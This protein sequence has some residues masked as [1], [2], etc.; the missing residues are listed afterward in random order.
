MK[1]FFRSLLLILAL[2]GLLMFLS[3]CG[4]GTLKSIG[5]SMSGVPKE[6]GTH[7][8]VGYGW[9][10]WGEGVTSSGGF[11]P[12]LFSGGVNMVFS[13]GCRMKHVDPFITQM[14]GDTVVLRINL[15]ESEKEASGLF[16]ANVSGFEFKPL[17]V[18][19]N[20]DDEYCFGSGYKPEKIDTSNYDS[21]YVELKFLFEGVPEGLY[22]LGIFREEWICVLYKK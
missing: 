12:D 3:S 17:V 2:L 19:D 18:C 15:T 1:T 9:D 13:S 22:I 5:D 16:S 11:Q 20:H 4:G 14:D 21:G 8:D 10:N 6:A 7:C